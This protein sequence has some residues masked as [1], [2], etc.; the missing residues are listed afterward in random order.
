LTVGSKHGPSSRTRQ[1]V[2]FDSCSSQ[3]SPQ[4]SFSTYAPL[5]Y[6]ARTARLGEP[7]VPSSSSACNRSD[8]SP[9][10]AAID[11]SDRS[12]SASPL[13]SS[14]AIFNEA[15]TIALLDGSEEIPS[16][17]LQL[18]VNV[19]RDLPDVRR[20]FCRTDRVLL[21]PRMITLINCS[22][23]PSGFRLDGGLDSRDL[24]QQAIDLEPDL[25]AFLQHPT[26]LFLLLLP[27]GLEAFIC[28]AWPLM[29]ACSSSIRCSNNAFSPLTLAKT[30]T[31]ALIRGLQLPS[32]F[33]RSSPG[34]A[35][36]AARVSGSA[37]SWLLIG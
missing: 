15:K 24:P 13:K 3:E 19:L 9:S 4:P 8:I 26:V 29:T 28:S 1:G 14:S 31:V 10:L 27:L 5:N 12:L 34:L 20:V 35:L 17:P 21:S 32:G 6:Q 30:A 37:A 11:A 22:M 23:P 2:S 7:P 18:F 25:L 16:R 33:R 36:K